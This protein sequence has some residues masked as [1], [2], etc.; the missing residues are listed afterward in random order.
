MYYQIFQQ[1]GKRCIKEYF[2]RLNINSQAIIAKTTKYNREAEVW[3][4]ET[5][6]QPEKVFGIKWGSSVYRCIFYII[7]YN[8]LKCINSFVNCLVRIKVENNI[9]FHFI[10][11][12]LIVVSTL[13][14][15]FWG[16]FSEVILEWWKLLHLCTSNLLIRMNF[17]KLTD[18]TRLFL[19]VF[20]FLFFFHL[21]NQ[22]QTKTQN[23]IL[24][25]DLIGDVTEDLI[26]IESASATFFFT[27][28]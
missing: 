24:I 26:A 18:K 13:T 23:L 3:V 21:K 12:F 20:I 16:A 8:H 5:K 7:S 19:F 10:S 2:K 1:G 22:R 4:E 14:L 25:K 6:Y 9:L 11:F 17:R 28:K 15:A 27:R